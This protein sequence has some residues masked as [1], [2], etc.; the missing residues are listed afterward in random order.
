MVEHTHDPAGPTFPS[1]HAKD[2]PHV[3]RG[4]FWMGSLQRLTVPLTRGRLR[5]HFNTQRSG[6]VEG[7]SGAGILT[8]PSTYTVTSYLS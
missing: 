7:V 5:A 8:G 2:D 3:E 4:E 6:A 1:R